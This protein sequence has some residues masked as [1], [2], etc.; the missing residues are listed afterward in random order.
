MNKTSKI[1]F[2]I[3]TTGLG[4]LINIT[5]ASAAIIKFD[6][7]FFDGNNTQ[8]GTGQFSYDDEITTCFETSFGGDCNSSDEYGKYD[9]ILVENALTDFSAVIDGE[10]WNGPYGHWWSDET[11][12]QLPGE[13]SVS[14]YGIWIGN[15][16]WFFGDPFFGLESLVMEIN[17][18]SNT[19][20]TGSWYQQITPENGGE[21]IMG[22]GFWQATKVEA[23]PS[24]T[25][26]EKILEPSTVPGVLI[27]V[28]LVY[29]FKPKGK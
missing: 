6:L 28:S 15:N 11:S 2:T 21:P 17:E 16:R 12:G 24:P 22:S 4:F 25:E 19:F 10:S 13:Q 7:G 20:G 3:A 14:R 26:T 27:A 8:V 9:T 29:Y 5:S 18:S 23:N 1:A